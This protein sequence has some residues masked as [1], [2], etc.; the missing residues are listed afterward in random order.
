MQKTTKTV[1]LIIVVVLVLGGG[2]AMYKKQGGF[3]NQTVTI[4]AVLPLSGDL[5]AYGEGAKNAA[6]M[7]IE[8]AG[9]KDTVKFIVEDDKGCAPVGG[10]S[11]AQKLLNVDKVSAIYGPMCSSEA[12]SIAPLTEPLKI[13]MVIGAATS[14]TL[15][16]AGNYIFR[17]IASDSIRAYAVANYAYAK[18]FKKAAFVFDNSQDALIQE[19]N[20]AKEAFTKAGGE[21]V[22]EESFGAKDVDFKTQLSKVKSSGAD[23]VFVGAFYKP[24]ALIIKQAREMK[25]DMQFVG[26]DESIDIKEF[27]TVGGNYVEGVIAPAMVKPNTEESKTFGARYKARF[28]IDATIYTA[29]GYDAMALLLKAIKAE[30]LQGDQIK[31]GLLKVGNNYPGV[32]GIITFNS[33]GDVEKP[34]VVKV[35]KS[36]VFEEVK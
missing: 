19:K 18:G 24:T 32:S 28:G 5:A 29:E 31:A 6:I 34:A 35:A 27:F 11:A 23:V 15:S 1:L 9:M 13:P 4:G 16:G 20:D 17:T 14:K 3:G 8:D 26:T 21:A 33:N 30:G 7:A 22:L 12:L 36:G 2:Y 25:M 10:V